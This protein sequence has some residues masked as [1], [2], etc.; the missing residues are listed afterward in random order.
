MGHLFRPENSQDQAH[1]NLPENRRELN[2]MD[3]GGQ[4]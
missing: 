4:V 3:S 2:A 1:V